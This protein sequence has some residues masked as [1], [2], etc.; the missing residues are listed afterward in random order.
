MVEVVLVA[1][2]ETFYSKASVFSL[3]ILVWIR[4]SWGSELWSTNPRNMKVV[5]LGVY[6][7][8]EHLTVAAFK[9]QYFLGNRVS[10][11]IRNERQYGLIL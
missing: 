6:A 5:V 10:A 3:R 11:A 9:F 1:G 8:F 7:N 2:Q 4:D